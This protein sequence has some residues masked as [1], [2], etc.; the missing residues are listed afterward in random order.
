MSEFAP[1]IGRRQHGEHTS[2]T[3]GE[4]VS[5]FV[6]RHLAERAGE[7]FDVRLGNN[8]GKL[9]SWAVRKGIPE[10]GQKHF[11][12]RT[13]LH[14][15]SYGPWEGEIPEGYGKGKVESRVRGRA[16]ITSVSPDG[17]SFTTA[18]E[19][20]PQR[21]RLQRI[22]GVKDWIL[23]NTTPTVPLEFRKTHMKSVPPEE[24]EKL[25]S[26][27]MIAQAKVDGS[28]EF[29]HILGPRIE[30]LSYRAQ[31]AT[32]YPI[33]HTERAGLAHRR[34]PGL[35]GDT[36]L[37]SELYG[38]SG[39]KS[40]TAAETGG[41]LNATVEHSL[42]KQKETGAELR[43]RL[44][45]VLRYRGRDLSEVPYEKRLELLKDIAS[46][47]DD[48]RFSVAEDVRDPAE[49]KAL[50]RRILSGKHP[51][52][53]EGVVFHPVGSADPV[54]VKRADEADVIITGV[55]PGSGKYSRSAGGFTYSLPEAPLETV[56]EVGSGLTDVQRQDLWDNQDDWIGRT[57]RIRAQEQFPSGAWRAPA[58]KALHEDI[59]QI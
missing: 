33:V 54:K 32:G 24:A 49:Q 40:L 50:L 1:G 26:P 58:F 15:E 44:L 48:P 31:K 18:D 9:Y 55:F 13:Y 45:D 12:A 5:F 3:P 10:P 8:K 2:L 38:A 4:I 35:P 39:R 20:Y 29:L 21:F 25:F 57:A 51:L 46:R 11:A 22:R 56:G 28:A 6:Q 42:Q 7:H 53:R 36:V 52:T 19:R 41:L 43:H 30:S 14:N 47:I 23:I 17:I 37:R 27:D 34:Y 59:P 16:L